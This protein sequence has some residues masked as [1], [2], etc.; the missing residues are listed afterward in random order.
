MHDLARLARVAA[1]ACRLAARAVETVKGPNKSAYID[2]AAACLREAT[3][4]L[5]VAR[6][7]NK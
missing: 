1:D 2:Q 5:K 3:K 6:E 4:A 7:A